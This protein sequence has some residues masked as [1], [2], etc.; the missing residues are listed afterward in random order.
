[1]YFPSLHG[2]H[3]FT[4]ISFGKEHDN[5]FILVLTDLFWTRM[6]VVR[7]DGKSPDQVGLCKRNDG[8]NW[9]WLP[10]WR[11]KLGMSLVYK[12]LK[13]FHWIFQKFCKHWPFPVWPLLALISTLYFCCWAHSIKHLN[14]YHA[15]LLFDCFT[16]LV[17]VSSIIISTFK[18]RNL[19]FL[20]LGKTYDY[21]IELHV[22]VPFFFKW[23]K[24]ITL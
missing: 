4:L 16:Y 22:K 23:Y 21:Y 7:R 18:F 20:S 13:R 6:K 3:L 10:R 14:R 8:R 15:L 2:F 24:S 17:F 1:M 11:D 5:Q 12:G 9:E 19:S